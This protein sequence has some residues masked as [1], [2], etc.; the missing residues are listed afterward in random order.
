MSLTDYR[1]AIVTGASSG[2]GEGLVRALCARNIAVTAVARRADALAAL[3]DETGCEPLPLD[4]R[5]S[6]AL[7]AAF[8][9][10][11]ADILVNNAGVGRGMEGMLETDP[12]DIDEITEI[13]LTA[14]LH[15]FRALVPGMVER[16]RGHV[17]NI[18][19]VAGLYPLRAPL[20]GATKGGVHLMSQNMRV[21]LVGSGVRVTEICPGRVHTPFFEA[22][23]QDQERARSFID[24]HELL[25]IEDIVDAALYALETPSRVNVATIEIMPVE[26]AVGGLTIRK[27]DEVGA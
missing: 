21:E 15:C 22:N 27:R 18:G 10:L 7:H 14:V 24:G 20:Y 13:N 26:Q 23:W 2:I 8:A 12:D 9:P 25:E 19:S 1:T 3:A 5:D 6:K 11:Q 4:L 16:G 17:V